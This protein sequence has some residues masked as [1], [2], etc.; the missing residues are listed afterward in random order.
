MKLTKLPALTAVLFAFVMAFAACSKEDDTTTPGG[1]TGK[2]PVKPSWADTLARKWVV[3][4]AT[5]KGQED[6]GSVGLEF[7]FKK[8]GTYDF[9]S[10]QHIGTWKYADS[11]YKTILLDEAVSTLKTTWSATVFTSK[12]LSV[13][14]KSPFTGGNAHWD[15]EAK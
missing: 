12:N 15:L 9:E 7:Q 3:K 5:H 1:N 8:D 2:P 13:D 14:F 10:G 4:K 6:P 11:A